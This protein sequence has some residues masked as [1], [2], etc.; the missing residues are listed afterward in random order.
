M[1]TDLAQLIDVP[2]ECCIELVGRRFAEGGGNHW[3]ESVKRII[4]TPDVPAYESVMVDYYEDCFRAHKNNLLH[5]F[6]ELVLI[7]SLKNN[8]HGVPMVIC[9]LSKTE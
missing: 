3:V 4:E 1:E 8:W 9:L 7:P 5:F 6:P 2:I